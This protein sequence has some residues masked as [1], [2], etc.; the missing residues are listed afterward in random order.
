[1]KKATKEKVKKYMIWIISIFVIGLMVI[2]PF[3]VFF[4]R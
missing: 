1:M 4:D 3:F 2:A